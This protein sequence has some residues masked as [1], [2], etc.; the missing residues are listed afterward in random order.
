MW[1]VSIILFLILSSLGGLAQTIIAQR[2]SELSSTDGFERLELLLE[3]TNYYKKEDLK[4]ARKYGRQANSLADSYIITALSYAERESI[5]IINSKLAY[6]EVLMNRKDYLEA[7]QIFSESKE[8]ATTYGLET[9]IS[10]AD[11][12]LATIDSLAAAGLVKDNF[13]S[14]TLGDIDLGSA[15]SKSTNSVAS[16]S[17]IKLAQM[18]EKSGD[19]TAAIQ[20]YENAATFLRKRGEIKQAEE[21]E[22]KVETFRE[23]Q[24]IDSLR[25][26][27]IDFPE[28]TDDVITNRIEEDSTR[29]LTIPEMKAIDIE[30]KDKLDQ[31][32]SRAEASEKGGDYAS[33][34][35][36]YKEFIALEQKYKGDSIQR[37]FAINMAESKME[38]L[39]QQ[40]EIADLNIKAIQKEQEAEAQV[41][42]I[43][44]VIA[45]V[46]ALASLWVLFMYL[47]KRK[48]HHQLTS[49]YVDLDEAK[50]K[51][52][53]AEKHISNLL[54]QQVSPEIA[55]A[56]ID[57]KP[58]RKKQ[59][60]AVMFL[61]IRGFTQKAEKMDAVQLIEYQNNVFGFMIEII[62]EMHGN[63]NQFM[64]DG[65][66]ATFG[67]PV[68][69]G[70]DAG[71]A[72]RAAKAILEQMK[73]KN[74]SGIIP[75]TVL[76]IGIHAGHV[77]TGNVGTDSRKQFSVTGNT[78]IIA[79]RVEQLN[80]EYGSQLIITEEVYDAINKDDIERKPS[81]YS[82]QVK[83]RSKP[84]RIVVMEE[85]SESA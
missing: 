58:Q 79:A 17:E 28:T 54:S 42:N 1:K 46:I 48:K 9:A 45:S 76:G 51:L 4:K 75:E 33:S 10:L 20:H 18:A 37:V 59:F 29:M 2:E 6:G 23:M 77:V 47:A 71:N 26:Q 60:V 14:R 30:E 7:K 3:I 38:R 35:N 40:N 27:I 78:V 52:E 66:M 70:N 22:Q 84:V 81:M 21:I 83:G 15:I 50:G 73:I 12:E 49:A 67:A 34:L 68:S 53:D 41:K 11:S 39:Q 31:L 80:K 24:A 65:F 72:Y 61:D 19:T 74:R 63:I 36:Y 5:L 43:L 85:V 62:Q 8:G 56:L 69:H 57:E 44:I 32:R 16:L 25:R 64:G 13:F 55:T 82:V